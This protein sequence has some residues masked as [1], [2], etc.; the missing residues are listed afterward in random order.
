MLKDKKINILVSQN[1]A[2]PG[3]MPRWEWAPIQSGGIW[4]Y[5][6]QLS[7]E[8]RFT[9]LMVQAQEEALFVISWKNGITTDMLIE[10]R[11]KYYNITR[12]DDFE[13]NKTDIRMYAKFSGDTL[14][15][16]S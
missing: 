15:P 14:Q 5:Y 1:V 6:R 12:I 4:A 16:I 8:E 11:G 3:D 10:F 2:E 13:G 9:A 7:G